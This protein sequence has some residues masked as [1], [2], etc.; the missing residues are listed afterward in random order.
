MLKGRVFFLWLLF[1]LLVVMPIWM[2]HVLSSRQDQAAI[3]RTPSTWCSSRLDIDRHHADHDV[4]IFFLCIY[5]YI[6]HT[7]PMNTICV[8][9]LGGI[10]FFSR[11]DFFFMFIFFLLTF[12]FCGKKKDFS[13]LLG[14]ITTI[15]C[16]IVKYFFLKIL[17]PFFSFL[18]F[19]LFFF[20]FF[21]WPT[22]IENDGNHCLLLVPFFTFWLEKISCFFP[23]F[24]SHGS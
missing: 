7:Q 8:M 4:K 16:G 3:C 22:R 2:W 11:N 6:L 20:S 21:W 18:L 19:F 14:S 10:Y 9:L 23:S 15:W 17:F 1:F 13:R 24:S 12:F 5:R